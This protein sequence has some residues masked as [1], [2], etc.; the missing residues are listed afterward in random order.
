MKMGVVFLQSVG[1]P[2]TMI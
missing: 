2:Y 1:I